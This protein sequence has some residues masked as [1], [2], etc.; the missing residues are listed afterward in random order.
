[1]NGLDFDTVLVPEEF[2]SGLSDYRL[3]AFDDKEVML[4]LETQVEVDGDFS[5]I[6]TKIQNLIG[7]QEMVANLQ[8][9]GMQNVVIL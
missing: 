4:N 5:L 7:L 9:Q 6:I 2:L 1:M 8:A 3:S